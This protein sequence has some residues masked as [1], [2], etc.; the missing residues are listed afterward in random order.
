VQRV[1]FPFAEIRVVSAPTPSGGPGGA[2]RVEQGSRRISQWRAAWTAASRSSRTSSGV[3]SVAGRGC[4]SAWEARGRPCGVAAGRDR[5][6]ELRE[7]ARFWASSSARG[8]PNH[9]RRDKG[10]LSPPAGEGAEGGGGG[11]GCPPRI[12]ARVGALLECVFLHSTPT[13]GVGAQVGAL[14]ELL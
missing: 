11:F 14:L 2:Q 5:Q 10:P 7:A 13:F 6:W 9:H 8:A 1:G 12:G 4:S 3:R